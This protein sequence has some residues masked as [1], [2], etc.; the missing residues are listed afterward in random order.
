MTDIAQ[1]WTFLSKY[2]HVLIFL[3][4]NPHARLHDVAEQ[5]GITEPSVLRLVTELEAADILRCINERRRNHYVIK[6]RVH[7]CVIPLSHIAQ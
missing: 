6:V 5:I 4:Y 2:V 7:T 1:G 3:A